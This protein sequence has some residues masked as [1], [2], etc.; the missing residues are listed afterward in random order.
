SESELYS[1]AFSP[2]GRRIGAVAQD[3]VLVWDKSN[4]QLLFS[5]AANTYD[6][7]MWHFG[8]ILAFSSDGKLVAPDKNRI[9]IRDALTGR[10][11]LP[12]PGHSGRVVCLA[13]S[14]DG[15]RLASGSSSDYDVKLW[16]TTTGQELLALRG[17][18]NGLLSLAFSPDGDRLAS[19]SADGTVKI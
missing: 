7:R 13:F 4:G 18:T 15:R 16:D 5:F 1:L 8:P 6:Q 14:L 10:Q 17:H 11:I 2:D 12:L 3:Q 19:S 9:S